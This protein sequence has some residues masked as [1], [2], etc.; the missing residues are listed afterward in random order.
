MKKNFI[1]LSVYFFHNS[2]ASLSINNKIICAYQEDRFVKKKNEVS[3]PL[4]SIKACL[5]YAGIKAFEV[6]KIGIVNDEDSFGSKNSI[7]NFLFKRQS[8]YSIDDWRYENENYWNPLLIKNKKLRSFFKTMGG[9]KK[10]SKDH[11]INI[12]FYNDKKKFSILKKNFFFEIKNFFLKLGFNENSIEFLPHYLMHHY[13]AFYSC[14][15]RDLK[16]NSM[17][18][19]CEGDGGR[20]NHAISIFKKSHGL[21]ILNGTKLFNLGRLYQWTTLGL[22]M[23]PYHDEYKVMGL[24]PYG[25]LNYQSLL[26]KEFSKFFKLNKKKNL[27]ELNQIP[28]DMFFQFKKIINNT[29]FDNVA[30]NLQGFLENQ[31]LTLFLHLKKKFKINN[32]FYGGGVAMNVKANLYLSTNLNIKNFFVPISPADES[33]VF[34]ANYY[35][36]EKFFLKKKF[37]LKKIEPLKNI[38]LGNNYHVKNIHLK[39]LKKYK[40]FKLN[41][42][43]IAKEF[44]KG[45]IIGRFSG[46]AEF[47]QRALGNRSILASINYP[48]VVNKI[49]QKIK[50]R[51]FWMPFAL[52]ILDS[53]IFK[54]FEKN[55][56]LCPYYMTTCYM[57]KKEININSFLNVIHQA[58]KTARPQV[59]TK[60]Q[61]I[62]YY[63]LLTKVKYDNGGIGA[64]LNT[65]FNIH[66]K[67]IVETIDDAIEVF[68]TTNL[69]GLILNK[70]YISKILI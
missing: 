58:D 25:K 60:K 6:D 28:K 70:L 18:V 37:D 15:K 43:K 11:H 14:L 33:N 44:S 40:I 36:M 66:K 62:E 48:G 1:T 26:Y 63:D 3:I 13:H 46:R 4:N 67:T 21:K 31:L 7:I 17:I 32:F 53:D 20:Y 39:K 5:K 57:L 45:K 50:S 8:R 27:I 55:N 38:Y 51:D 64:L 9:T 29:R 10:I 22:N 2:S 47:G 56:H 34:G 69:D 54:Y 24:A 30:A 23:L 42:H 59:V 61:N 68:E 41:H 19:H 16:G 49:N 52:S 35:L 65:S 12:S